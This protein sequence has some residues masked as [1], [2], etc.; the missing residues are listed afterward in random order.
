[1]KE[2][3][4]VMYAV[5]QHMRKIGLGYARPASL[6]REMGFTRAEVLLALW[7]LRRDNAVACRPDGRWYKKAVAND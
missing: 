6:A 3:C 4:D 2:A 1:M 7:L 5:A